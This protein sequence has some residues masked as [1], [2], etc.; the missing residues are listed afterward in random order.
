MAIGR[1]ALAVG[2]PAAAIAAVGYGGY[3]IYAGAQTRK[4]EELAA[5]ITAGETE[6]PQEKA[7]I[8]TNIARWAKQK[9]DLA[10]REAAFETAAFMGAFAAPGM[11]GTFAGPT[12]I[13]PELALAAAA[14]IAAA[15]PR[16]VAGMTQLGAGAWSLPGGGGAEEL[17]L[18]S[19]RQLGPGRYEII[20]DLQPSVP[21]GLLD[22]ATGA[23]MEDAQFAGEAI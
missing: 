18:R 16:T 9:E 14:P 20:L 5:A 8:A 3:S 4:S 12:A 10:A 6:T 2:G 15:A 22:D 7:L 23:W 1:G 11:A 13:A 17:S 19:L 21:A